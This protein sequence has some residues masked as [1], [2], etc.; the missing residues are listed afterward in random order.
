[1]IIDTCNDFD[2]AFNSRTAEFIHE[3]DDRVIATVIVNGETLP[4]S[5]YRPDQQFHVDIH[6]PFRIK[7]EATLKAYESFAQR[8]ETAFNLWIDPF[9][10]EVKY[11]D[12]LAEASAEELDRVIQRGVERLEQEWGSLAFYHKVSEEEEGSS[13]SARGGR[14]GFL[15]LLRDCMMDEDD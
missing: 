6:P 11:C 4:V 13:E 1:M 8:P 10:G 14:K 3:S 5:L 15:D 7:E 2:F 12:R 9:D